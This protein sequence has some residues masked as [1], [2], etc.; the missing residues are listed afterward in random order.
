MDR[1]FTG[2]R[3]WGL[4]LGGENAVDDSLRAL[5]KLNKMGEFRR[6]NVSG[7]EKFL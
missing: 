5:Y 4:D 1:C 7:H 3:V 2:L 6:D